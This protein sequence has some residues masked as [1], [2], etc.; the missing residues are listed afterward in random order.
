MMKLK[1]QIPRISIQQ[2]CTIGA[3][4]SSVCDINDDLLNPESNAM[5]SDQKADLSHMTV[6]SIH[7]VES[8][9][10]SEMSDIPITSLFQMLQQSEEDIILAKHGYRKIRKVCDTLQGELMKAE[11]IGNNEVVEIGS[12]VA[13]KKVCHLCL[14]NSMINLMITNQHK[15]NRDIS[16]QSIAKQRDN[17]TV[18]FCISENILKEAQILKHLTMDN[19]IHGGYCVKFVDFFSTATDHYLVTEYVDGMKLS[20]FIKIVHT[21][22]IATNKLSLTKY[23]KI[24]KFIL[25]QLCTTLR[26]LHDVYHCMLFICFSYLICFRYC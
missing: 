12:H 14:S 24:T 10:G 9:R 21:Q 25:W 20:E 1:V 17:E 3:D 2:S 16:D 6:K 19:S 23:H 4:L 15:V 13:I 22:Y 18:T 26:L 7:T 8:S 5:P 11:V